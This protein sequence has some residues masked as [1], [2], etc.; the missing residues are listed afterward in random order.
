MVVS[1]PLAESKSS[2]PCREYAEGQQLKNFT[3][4]FRDS[5]FLT[6]GAYWRYLFCPFKIPETLLSLSVVG[7]QRRAA[8]HEHGL[9]KILFCKLPSQLHK[10]SK[11]RQRADVYIR[12][13]ECR[14]ASER[15]Q[16]SKG[17]FC[18]CAC[19]VFKAIQTKYSS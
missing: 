15:S 6:C 17:G 4:Y 1:L 12:A 11:V 10:G 19:C 8:E 2:L 14:R 5:L 18:V 13:R 7:S 16:V 3:L 9:Q